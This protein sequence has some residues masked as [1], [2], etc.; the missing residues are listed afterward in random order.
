MPALRNFVPRSPN[1]PVPIPP[2]DLV[3]KAAAVKEFDQRV[4]SGL[5][6][7]ADERVNA[8]LLSLVFQ[9][10][11]CHDFSVAGRACRLRR[12]AASLPSAWGIAHLSDIDVGGILH[13]NSSALQCPAAIVLVLPLW[14]YVRAS[15]LNTSP[16]WRGGP[17]TQSRS[18]SSEE[19]AKALYR[20]SHESSTS[21]PI[22]PM[23]AMR[24]QQT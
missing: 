13:L 11:D 21:T 9:F 22:S 3:A 5:A 6:H 20:G 17:V 8:A 4:R 23:S 19:M 16:G 10:L 12:N 15:R 14:R 1:E 7:A 24:I 18:I 2:V